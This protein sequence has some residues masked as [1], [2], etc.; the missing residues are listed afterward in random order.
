M[1]H[2]VGPSFE[3]ISG[4]GP[5]GAIIHYRANE[6]TNRKITRDELYLVDSGGQ[7]KV[8]IRQRFS[9]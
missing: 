8:R 3:T 5:N 7:Y 2:Y 6:D 1:D 4:S 9:R